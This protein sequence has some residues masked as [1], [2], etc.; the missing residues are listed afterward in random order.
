MITMVLKRG[1]KVLGVR[2]P[3]EEEEKRKKMHGHSHGGKKCCN[4][5]HGG[6]GQYTYEQVM[7][8]PVLRTQYSKQQRQKKRIA[9]ATRLGICLAIFALWW[10]YGS[11][12]DEYLDPPKDRAESV[13][14]RLR[15]AGVKVTAPVDST[16]QNDDGH[17]PSTT[18]KQD[19]KHHVSSIPI[20]PMQHQSWKN[21]NTASQTFLQSYAKEVGV[22]QL[23]DG[24]MYKV[25]TAGKGT[26]HPTLDSPCKVHYEGKLPN[27]VI[28][29]SSYARGSPS[30][31]A[32][33]QVIKGWTEVLQKMVEG[34]V[35]EVVI[36]S[37]L[38]YGDRGSGHDIKG[39]DTLIFKMQLITIT[40]KK[41]KEAHGV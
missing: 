21:S 8:D 15:S 26:Y 24:L 12:V 29:D 3:K 30:T 28:F 33:N 14:A 10:F 9:V 41:V 1:L 38:G 35:W 18:L 20:D 16:P 37:D 11:S 23:D 32:P 5:N 13:N 4:K 40:G 31:F 27:G 2:P 17:P 36:P 39:G 22:N 19:D 25:L 7:S 34:D 6:V